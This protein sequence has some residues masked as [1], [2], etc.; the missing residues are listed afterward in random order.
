VKP[1]AGI[2]P[3]LD[4]EDANLETLAVASSLENT[5]SSHFLGKHILTFIAATTLVSLVA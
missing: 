1:I 2:C 5:D 4:H 3:E